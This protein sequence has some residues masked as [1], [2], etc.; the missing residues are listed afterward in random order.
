VGGIGSRAVRIALVALAV[1]A[2]FGI[3]FFVG[4]EITRPASPPGLSAQDGL[5]PWKSVDADL[6]RYRVIRSFAV[7]LQDPRGI[8]CG[9]DGTV[10]VC[11]D[12]AL[13]SMTAAGAVKKRFT[14]DGEPR[15]VAAAPDG[16][17]FVGMA[18]HVVA[19]DPLRGDAEMWPD[20]GSQA[21]VTSVSASPQGVFVADAGNREV[22][23]FD[24][25]GTLKGRVGGGF[26]VPSPF[27]DLVASPDGTLWVADPGQQSVRHYGA[28]GELLGSWGKSSL[29]IEGFG[30]CC[31]PAHIAQLPC[32]R[33]VT[34]EKGILRVKVY[35]PDGKLSAVVAAPRDLPLTETSLDIATRMANGGEILVL[36]P[37]QRTVRVY[38]GKEAGNGG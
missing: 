34:S 2:T 20:L 25:G 13:L 27:F 16:R 1:A 37:S 36:V 31:N 3:G 5:E 14:L 19:L 18:D 28:K 23:R 22:L 35:E 9:A 11:G 17:L 12:R 21:I 15:C 6:V 26:I 38:A 4:R 8:A 29:E 32:G 33:I 10:Y 7:D 30:G 24:L